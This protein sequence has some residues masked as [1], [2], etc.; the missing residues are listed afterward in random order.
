MSGCFKPGYPDDGLIKYG[1]AS[2]KGG[3]HSIIIY[4]GS[5]QALVHPYLFNEFRFSP[6]STHQQREVE[7]KMEIFEVF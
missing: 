1:L 4:L 2:Q 6:H 3:K 7:L 5:I